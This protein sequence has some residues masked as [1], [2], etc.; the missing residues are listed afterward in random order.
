MQ[1]FDIT[2]DRY[3]IFVAFSETFGISVTEIHEFNNFGNP[4]EL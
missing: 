3:K 2:F 1:E 4:F